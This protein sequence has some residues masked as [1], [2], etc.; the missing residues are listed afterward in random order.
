MAWRV[1]DV[2]VSIYVRVCAMCMWLRIV[3]SAVSKRSLTLL[4]G[5]NRLLYT[6]LRTSS[7][8]HTGVHTF[9]HI[10]YSHACP[11]CLHSMPHTQ[12]SAR[13]MKLR[14]SRRAAPR[15]WPAYCA[16]HPSSQSPS[17]HLR[18]MCATWPDCAVCPSALASYWHCVCA[19]LE[20][21]ASGIECCAIW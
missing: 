18:Y 4:K 1:V 16:R 12:L 13:N 14:T 21:I 15:R 3:G 19:C 8:L 11:T 20:V 17:V 5:S 10:F 7:C 6:C 9:A 2:S